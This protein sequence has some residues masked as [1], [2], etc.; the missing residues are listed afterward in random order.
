MTTI[1]LKD[2]YYENCVTFPI[3]GNW[4]LN[5]GVAIV[6]DAKNETVGAYRTLKGEIEQETEKAIYFTCKASMFDSRCHII[7][8]VDWHMWLPKKGLIS[9][10]P[11]MYFDGGEGA[12]VDACM[13]K[14]LNE[15]KSFASVK[16]W[17][18]G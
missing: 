15:H 11:Y 5:W 3:N 9:N 8:T 18:F 7:K 10:A 17:A 4:F 2:W 1:V 6:P 14:F 13:L 16:T 12:Q